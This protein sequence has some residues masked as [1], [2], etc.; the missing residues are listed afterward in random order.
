LMV[1]QPLKAQPAIASAAMARIWRLL[2]GIGG[3]LQT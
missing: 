1:P 2:I 3:T